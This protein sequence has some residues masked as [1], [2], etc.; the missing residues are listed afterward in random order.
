M[1]PPVCRKPADSHN[2]CDA[3]NI[4]CSAPLPCRRVFFPSYLAMASSTHAFVVHLPILS[5]SSFLTL[6]DSFLYK[7]ASPT[8][9]KLTM[10][11]SHAQ[12]DRTGLG[13]CHQLLLPDRSVRPVIPCSFYVLWTGLI[14]EPPS[15][16]TGR[17]KETGGSK[18]G[19]REPFRSDHD[20]HH[21]LTDSTGSTM[22]ILIVVA[23][24]LL[25]LSVAGFSLTSRSS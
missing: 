23:L 8:S 21:L 13:R 11:R 4:P 22:C 7:T 12:T 10:A 1:S 3:T 6:V 18:N 9:S 20:D 24:R 2:A 16:S 17:G 14:Q 19:H 25:K 5:L 15:D